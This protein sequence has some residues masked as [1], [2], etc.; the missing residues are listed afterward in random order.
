MESENFEPSKFKTVPPENSN[1]MLK[2]NR[3]E[4]VKQ[5][6]SPTDK[7]KMKWNEMECKDF[8]PSKSKTASVCTEKIII[9]LVQTLQ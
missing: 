8:E 2:E 9:K 4:A 3:L 5:N 7:D 1:P 6:Q